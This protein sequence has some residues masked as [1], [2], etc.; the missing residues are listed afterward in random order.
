MEHDPIAA[1]GTWSWMIEYYPAI[2][3]A[4]VGLVLASGSLFALRG[5]L[6]LNNQPAAQHWALR[7]LSCAIDIARLGAAGVLMSMVHMYPISH[8]GLT[9]KMALLLV[10]IALGSYALRRARSR[11]ARLAC[12]LAA[13]ATYLL[14]FGIARAHHPLGWLRG[15]GWA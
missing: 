5:L 7:R 3:S 8:D 12:L 2:K 4:H 10:Y 14:M 11:G 1:E 15:W 9:L 13:L 6:S